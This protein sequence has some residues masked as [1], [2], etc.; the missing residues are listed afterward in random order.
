LQNF[1]SALFFSFPSPT[2]GA[3]RG[4]AGGGCSVFQYFS[5]SKISRGIFILLLLVS[6]NGCVSKNAIPDL[7]ETFAKNDTRPFGGNIA[8]RLLQNAFPEWEIRLVKKPVLIEF[9]ESEDTASL[10]FCI[11]KNNFESE[12]DAIALLNFVHKGNTAFIA[13]PKTD[14]FLLSKLSIKQ[15]NPNWL[16]D[17]FSALYKNTSLSLSPEVMDQTPNQPFQYYYLPLANY[18]ADIKAPY[19][20]IIGHNE[21]G[22]PDCILIYWGKGKIYLHCDP[23]AFSNYFL[24]KNN[25]YLY[26]QQLLR[27]TAKS[28]EHIYWDD[29]Y[30]KSNQSNTNNSFST[31]SELFKH[32][33]L[34]K[35]FW[36]SLLLLALYVFFG[37]KRR[38][39]VIPEIKPNENSSVAFT[40]TIAMLYLQQKD[41]KNI[42]DKTISYFNEHIR[43]NYYLNTNLTNNEFIETLS[44]KS[45]VPLEQTTSLYNTIN[46]INSSLRVDAYQLLS[47]N[48][49]IQQFYKK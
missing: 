7:R 40:E 47:L 46:Q 14:T 21:K 4:R 36:L 15:P 20:K 49:Q 16:F 27:L 42:A 13:S 28:P 44:K 1:L 41:N 23:R 22:Q 19:Y 34:A 30:N 24:L 45:G 17:N 35:A 5:F 18:F 37:G 33:P 32:P 25:N 8:Y 26:M 9:D 29:Y 31:F 3:I 11:S 2:V 6:F 38:Q 43:N 10:Y 39:R 48:K 12:N